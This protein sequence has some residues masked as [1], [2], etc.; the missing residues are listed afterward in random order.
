MNNQQFLEQRVCYL[1]NQLREVQIEK[2][3][4]VAQYDVRIAM[5]RENINSIERQLQNKTEQPREIYT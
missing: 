5:L 1:E 2:R 3:V 4:S